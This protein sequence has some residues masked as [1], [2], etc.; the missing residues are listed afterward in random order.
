M[1]STYIF[2]KKGHSAFLNAEKWA[3]LILGSRKTGRVVL[4]KLPRGNTMFVF[5]FM[6]AYISKI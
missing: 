3:G 4:L 5:V 2:A 6:H 1:V